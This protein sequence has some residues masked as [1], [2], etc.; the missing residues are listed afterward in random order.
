MILS[1]ECLPHRMLRPVA[2]GWVF[3]GLCVSVPTIDDLGHEFRSVLA[4]LLNT[5]RILFPRDSEP[6]SASQGAPD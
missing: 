1:L 4:L 3:L 6:Q 2:S 5:G